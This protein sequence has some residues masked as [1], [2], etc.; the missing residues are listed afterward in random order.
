MTIPRG[1]RVIIARNGKD[2][3]PNKL[4]TIDTE[5]TLSLQS[6]FES[7]LNST[8]VNKTATLLSGIV[9]STSGLTISS[10]FKEIGYQIWT[11]T[12]PLTFAFTTTLNM[13]TSGLIDVVAPS[14]TLMKLVLPK[15]AT[16]GKGFGLEAPGPTI[17]DAIS[18]K[19][20]FS[21]KY[22]FRCGIVYLP[23]IIITKAEPTYSDDLDSAGYP[24]WCTMQM[25]VSSVF[26]A[27]D[28][29]IDNFSWAPSGEE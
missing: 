23:N 14:I 7:L 15:E 22:S 20:R 17:L 28:K 13:R 6:H 12:D 9:Q 3:L 4:L 8:G 16:S 21:N 1:K 19:A 18:G 25:E 27:T 2:I 5:V 11:G 24:I 29:L 26:V 10:A